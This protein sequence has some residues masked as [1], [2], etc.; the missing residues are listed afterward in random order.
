MSSPANGKTTTA[1]L[2]SWLLR[3]QIPSGGESGW[4][5]PHLRRHGGSGEPGRFRRQA[6]GRLGSFRDREASLPRAVSEVHP[7]TTAVLNLFRDQLDRY[8]ELESIA[9]KIERALGS[10][11][12]SAHVV[13]NADDPRVAE[14]GLHL[15]HKPTWYGLEDRSVA[16]KSFARARSTLKSSVPPPKSTVST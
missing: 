13:L 14:I 3:A 11:G 10:L 9:K 7:R 5:Q 12:E 4:R 1:R 15:A 8:G 2:V 6:E 16:S